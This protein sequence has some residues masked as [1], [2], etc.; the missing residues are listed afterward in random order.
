M[1]AGITWGESLR[2]AEIFVH[3]VKVF[4]PVFESGTA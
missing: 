3:T 4:R 1:L 2:A